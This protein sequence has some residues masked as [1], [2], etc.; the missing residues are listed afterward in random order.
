MITLPEVYLHGIKYENY[1]VFMM[2]RK[3]A[4]EKICESGSMNTIILRRSSNSVDLDPN[5]YFVLTR[6]ENANRPSMNVIFTKNAFQEC[7]GRLERM[8]RY[9]IP[10]DTLWIRSGPKE[11]MEKV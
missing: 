6:M 4:E 3:E 2:S 10:G 11:Y 7:E 1:P 8:V 5:T 9:L